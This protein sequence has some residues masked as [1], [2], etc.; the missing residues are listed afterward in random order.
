MV[1]SIALSENPFKID[2]QPKG[3]FIT[4]FDGTLLRSDRSLAAEDINALERLGARDIVRVIATGRSMHSFNRVA[5]DNLPVEFVI[6]STGA[7]ICRHPSGNI[8]RKCMLEPHEV[9]RAGEVLTKARLDFM[10]HFPIPDN[11]KFAYV[12][13]D[14]KN[15]DFERRRSLYSDFCRPLHEAVHEFGPATQLLAVVSGQNGVPT[16]EMIRR[17]LPELNVI[18]TTS[19]LDGKSTWI[20]IFPAHVSKSQTASWLAEKLD[21][22]RKQIVSVGNDYNDLDLLVWSESSYVVANAPAALK[23]QFPV[24]ASNNDG[25]IAEAVDRWLATRA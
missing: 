2:G 11:H 13:V 19:P 5:V 7:G 22:D 3:M 1:N 4:D 9:K 6:F 24:V 23:T 21:I 16:L 15:A 20:E 18:H 10:I 17:Q 8:C 12:V 25:G 14:R